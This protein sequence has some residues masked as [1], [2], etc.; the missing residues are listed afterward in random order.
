MS[1][2]SPIDVPT[3]DD[4]PTVNVGPA[5]VID[6]QSDDDDR[7]A[8]GSGSEGWNFF[9]S[10][11]AIDQAW[12]EWIAWQLEDAGYRV[13]IQ[14]WD[15][16]PG[17]QLR[18]RMQQGMENAQRTVA[19]LSNAY[20][21]SVFGEEEWHAAY[22]RDPHGFAR[23]LL[24]IRIENCARPGV[25]RTIVSIDLF[26]QS[27]EQA[28]SHLRSQMGHALIGRAKSNMAPSFPARLNS[29]AGEPAFPPDQ[30]AS[31]VISDTL[32]ERWTLEARLA[33]ERR[34]AGQ[35][36]R[37]TLV[38]AHN[39]AVELNG[40]GDHQAAR[41]LA[42]DTLQRQRRTLGVDHPRT[43][44]TA[45]NLAIALSSLGDYQATRTIAED[46]LEQQRRVLG[47]DHADTLATANNLVFALNGLG[48]RRAARSL[49]R[50]IDRARHQA[51]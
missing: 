7:D 39:L 25:L 24:P 12:A 21:D 51:P 35:D 47:P 10:Y 48:K 11:A 3:S 26:D 20:L 2:R 40:L 29:P 9:I 44:A 28:S 34:T 22:S 1:S 50:E 23:K 49:T 18:I 15:L 19:V 8:A 27:P 42:E 13:L 4:D 36:R 38:T 46:T 14:A 45:Q 32:K 17:S 6:H 30:A 41:E 16:M 5:Q 31:P 37:R 43:L 33:Y